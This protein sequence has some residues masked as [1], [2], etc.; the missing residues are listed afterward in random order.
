MNVAA[1][2]W[3]IIYNNLGKWSSFD[4]M[5]TNYYIHISIRRPFLAGSTQLGSAFFLIS[6]HISLLISNE[7]NRPVFQ[8]VSSM[9]WLKIILPKTPFQTGPFSCVS[10]STSLMIVQ[11]MDQRG[12][13]AAKAGSSWSQSFFNFSHHGHPRNFIT[14]QQRDYTV[15]AYW[16]SCLLKYYK[17]RLKK[18][19]TNMAWGT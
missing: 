9:R 1:C 3:M 5:P 17:H 6:V 8:L 16:V 7:L 18:S 13:L 2:A 14:Y 19:I 4:K 12:C 11:Y 10:Y 15:Y